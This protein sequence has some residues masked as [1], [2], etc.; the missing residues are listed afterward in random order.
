MSAEEAWVKLYKATPASRDSQVSYYRLGAAVAFC[1]D[2][3]LRSLGSSL[4]AL[5]R[6]LWSAVW[7]ILSRLLQR[8]PAPVAQIRGHGS[9]L[10][11]LTSGL[12][13]QSAV[14]IGAIGCNSLVCGWCPSSKRRPIMG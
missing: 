5:L 3:R 13:T 2:V 8:R 9:L 7:R 6:H 4:A 14:P 1:L 11:N 12:M 10:Q